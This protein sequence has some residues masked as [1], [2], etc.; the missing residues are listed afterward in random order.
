VNPVVGVDHKLGLAGTGQAD[1]EWR[2]VQNTPPGVN[3][4]VTQAGGKAFVDPDK[5]HVARRV[6]YQGNRLPL[7]CPAQA[8]PAAPV[9]T[10]LV[11]AVGLN[12]ARAQEQRAKQ[13]HE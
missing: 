8:Q 3:V 7:V 10:R 2:I 6:A 13:E 11:A 9:R 12:L 4:G 5:V 1:L